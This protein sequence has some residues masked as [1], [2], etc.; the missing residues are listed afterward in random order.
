[1]SGD[2]RW[3]AAHAGVPT[4]AMA[5]SRAVWGVCAMSLRAGAEVGVSAG[6]RPRIGG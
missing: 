4:V 1:V 5:T 6:W 3:R 2:G